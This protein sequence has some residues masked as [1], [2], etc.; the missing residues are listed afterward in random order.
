MPL[1]RAQNACVLTVVIAVVVVGA[2][3]DSARDALPLEAGLAKQMATKSPVVSEERSTTG[4]H[5]I[6][7]IKGLHATFVV[8]GAPDLVL[9]T[10]WDVEKFP[11]MFPDI[12]EMHVRARAESRIDVE[13]FVDA[14]VKKA[15]YT[16]RREIDREVR[17]IRWREVGEGD[18]RHIRGSWSVRP[19]RDA[20]H[21]LVVYASFVDV[22]M[23]VPTS[24]VRDLALKKVDELATRVRTA[25]ARASAEQTTRDALERAVTSPTESTATT[26]RAPQ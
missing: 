11:E 10:L 5:G 26:V 8:A 14:V 1:S 6:E 24:L 23:I 19:T 12:E 20:Q 9:S 22:G 7:G 21:S 13:F 4:A 3:A 18:V 2:R 17:T 16:L 15:R 25:V